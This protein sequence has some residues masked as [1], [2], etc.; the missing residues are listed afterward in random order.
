MYRYDDSP[1]VIE[2]IVSGLSYITM[3]MIGFIWL[4]L[5]VFTRSNLRPFTQYHIFQS[6][7][8]AIALFLLNMLLGF[9]FNLLSFIPFINRLVAQIIFYFNAPLIGP[10]SIIQA[11]LYGIILYL[12]IT[13]FMGI[14]SRIPYVSD[15]IDKNVGRR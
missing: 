9:V 2:R 12:A 3:G 14:Y 7:F 11:L 13:A 6:I 8:I 10:Y 5:G 1:Y 15:I 4:I